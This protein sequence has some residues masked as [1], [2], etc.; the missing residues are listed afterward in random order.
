MVFGGSVSVG[1]HGP[2]LVGFVG[3]LVVSLISVAP[4]IF[5]L[6]S[7]MRLPGFLMF[8]CRSVVD[9]PSVAYI[10]M[11]IPLSCEGLWMR[12]E[13]HTQVTSCEPSS[14]E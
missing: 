10:L 7:S 9:S 13:S 5:P 8:G 3:L 2:R 6:D 12:N 1:P 11:L 14:N 4:S